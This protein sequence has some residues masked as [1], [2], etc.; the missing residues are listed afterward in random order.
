MIRKMKNISKYFAFLLIGVSSTSFAQSI[1]TASIGVTIVTPIG[2]T[3][4]VDMDFGNIA[5]GM[6]AG[7]T[8]VLGTD[9]SRSTTGD[10]TLPSAKGSP[11]AAAFIVTGAGNY[12]YTISLPSSSIRM[13]GS[14]ANVTIGSFVSSPASIGTLTSGTQVVNVGATLT[15]P[16]STA[17]DIYTNSS[18]LSIT[19]NYN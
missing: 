10:A 7:G 13:N 12:T 9:G 6:S 1:A 2:I 8:A 17:A 15:I 11:K 14:T 4:S 19:V 16:P 18:D 5:T 3:K